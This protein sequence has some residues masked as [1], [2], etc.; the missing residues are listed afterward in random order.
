MGKGSTDRAWEPH[1]KIPVP[2]NNSLILILHSEL[3]ETYSFI[4]ER[5][6]IKWFGRKDNR[7]GILLNRTDGGE[8]VS[9]LIHSQESI[10]KRINS[11]TGKKR[12]K[13]AKLNISNSRKGVSSSVKKGD[14]RLQSTK[15][16]ISNKCLERVK[17]KSHNLLKQKD[18]SSVASNLSKIGQHNWQKTKNLVKCYDKQGNYML[19]TTDEYRTQTGDMRLWEYVSVA[20]NEGKRRKN[21]L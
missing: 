9:G 6:Y 8:G 4:L 17:N 20:S 11:N 12:S 16:K 19:I 7:T 5:Y 15:E 3:S 2:K 13:Q 1:G 21:N 14:V 10:Q 18:G